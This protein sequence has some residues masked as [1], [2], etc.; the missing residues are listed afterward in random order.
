MVNNIVLLAGSVAVA[1]GGLAFVFLGGD[2]RADQR[3]MAIAKTDTKARATTVDRAA[4]KKQIAESLM[5]LEKNSKRKR[6]DMQTRIEQAGLSIKRQQ[7]LLIFVIA[8]LVLGALS[9]VKWGSPLVSGLVAVM[10]IVGL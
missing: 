1:M 4:K 2:S 8:G 7:Y 5:E 9:Y 3:R 10:V 6:V